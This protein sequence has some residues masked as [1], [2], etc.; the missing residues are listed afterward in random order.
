MSLY[1]ENKYPKHFITSLIPIIF[2]VGFASLI[3]H[4]KVQENI[5]IKKIYI[6]YFIVVILGLTA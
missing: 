3:L 1:K 4:T 2:F 5:Y 6:Y